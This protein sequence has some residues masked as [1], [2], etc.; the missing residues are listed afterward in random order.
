MGHGTGWV[1]G[2][3][4]P[5]DATVIHAVPIHEQSGA[6]NITLRTRSCTGPYKDRKWVENGIFVGALCLSAG[7]PGAEG[8]GG[9]AA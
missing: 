6:M 9:F 8:A 4:A 1:H 3:K 7:T 5:Q 2:P